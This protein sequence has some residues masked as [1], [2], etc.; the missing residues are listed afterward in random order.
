MKKT[1]SFAKNAV[2]VF[3]HITTRC[4]LKCAH[5][6]I[7]RKQHGDLTLDAQTVKQ[8]LSLFPG[9]AKDANLI[10]LGGEPTLHP[11]LAAIVKEARRLG[12]ASITI[13]TNGYLFYD[14][15]EKITPAD[16][17]FFSFSLDGAT[18]AT[19][20]TIRGEGCYEACT[21]GIK[22]AVEKGF[23]ASLIYTVS[24]RNLHELADMPDLLADL[25]VSRFFI[26]VIGIRG[27]SAEPGKEGLQ[28]TRRQWEKNVPP[29]ARKVAQMGIPVTYP[30]V[31]LEPGEVF[32][33]AGR[34]AE[35][36]F[37]FPNGRVYKCPLCEDYPLHSLEIKDGSLHHTSGINE[38]DLF[39]LDIPEGC[40]MNKLVQAGNISYDSEGRPSR[41]IACCLLK[42]EIPAC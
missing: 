34:V 9:R 19:N 38:A 22:R 39:C 8:W 17:D 20:D 7:N 27:R 28:L 18:A 11:D 21:R 23:A 16:A 30:R 42:E 33:C 1:V 4:N 3:F 32:E 41:K 29:V 2:N 15:T 14:I 37:I 24:G 13:D 25:G 31:F 6:Y 36:Y 40:V 35:N 5:C 12:Y 10:L 26:Q